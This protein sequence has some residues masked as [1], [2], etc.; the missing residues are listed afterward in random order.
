[1]DLDVLV[2][3]ADVSR[4]QQALAILGYRLPQGMSSATAR[5]IFGALGAWPLAGPGRLPVDLHWRLAH[6][7]FPSPL[8]AAAVLRSAA[9]VEIGGHAIAV[10]NPTHT[11]LLTLL[12]AAKHLWCTLDMVAAIAA[13][14][15]RSDVDWPAVRHL[16]LQARGWNGC[17]TGLRIAVE[18]LGAEMPSRL[19]AA[20]WPHA[21]QYLRSEAISA[22]QL[23]AGVFQDRWVERRAHRAAFDRP[24]DRLAYDVWRLVAPTPL[25]WAWC[26]LPDRLRWF[27]VP[28]RLT[29]LGLAAARRAARQEAP[30]FTDPRSSPDS[31][32][33]R[34]RAR[35]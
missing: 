25:E 7:R 31:S 6:V 1:V 29:R 27:Y 20:P 34:D 28:V 4:A 2:S 21:T 19:R 13:L 35:V 12:H 18:L 9:S 26:P 15:R 32:D 17:A 23:P 22:L 11:A 16:A 30:D 8:D 10:P 5:A 33:C 14:M 24:F 3:P